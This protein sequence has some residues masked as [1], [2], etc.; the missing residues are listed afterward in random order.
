MNSLDLNGSKIHA[1]YL[2]E[3]RNDM[4][5]WWHD[6]M[7]M[8]Q[9]WM[10]WTKQNTQR[11]QETLEGIWSSGL[12]ASQHYTTTRGSR[13]DIQNG[14]RG[15]TEEKREKVKLSCFFAKR[16]KPKNLEK[17]K[18]F[19][20][21]N[22]TEMNEVENTPLEKRNKEEQLRAALRLKRKGIE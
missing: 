6:A 5:A 7:H 21:K 10:Q 19:R 18:P 9:R 8:M 12:G 13:P 20:E 17:V 16:V 3:K 15:K 4:M 11:N 2:V 14:I 1:I 22:T